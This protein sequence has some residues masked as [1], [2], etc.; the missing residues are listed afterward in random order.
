MN[1][2]IASIIASLVFVAAL[3]SCAAELVG[4]ARVVDGDTIEIQSQRIRLFGVDAPESSQ[5]CLRGGQPERCGQIAA[6]A[7]ADKIA[8]Q[9]V[10]CTQRD[11]D[12]YGRVVAVCYAGGIDLNG[13][14]VEQGH[15][16]AFR[17]YSTDYAA[18][19]DRARS[20]RR[21][22][23][24]TVFDDPAEYRRQHPR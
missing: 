16:V 23:W 6:N 22:I 3:P 20:A 2:K 18:A 17:R 5:I 19:E 9:T 4:Q 21:G 7:L 8:R 15:A 10:R 13:W 11:K 24:A 14:L 12:R 1:S